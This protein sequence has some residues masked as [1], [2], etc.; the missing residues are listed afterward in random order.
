MATI[1]P[2]ALKTGDEV[3]VIA[4]A[5]SLALISPSVRQIARERLEMELG[6]K[7]TFGKHVEERDRYVSSS[8]KSRVDDLHEAF[9]DKNVKA[10]FSAVGGT[11][12]EELLERIDWNLIKRNP[13]VFCGFSD[14]TTLSNAIYG[15]TGLV[16]FSGPHYSSFGMKRGFEYTM[17]QFKKAVMGTHRHQVLSSANWSDDA[18]YM[19]Q[20]K[21]QFIANLG[22]KVF[23]QGVAKGTIIGGNIGTLAIL[24]GS[25]YMP[26]L[27][28]SILFLEECGDCEGSRDFT[29]RQFGALVRQPGFDKIKGI[30]F[31]RFQK[32]TRWEPTDFQELISRRPELAKRNI[33]II[34]GVDFGHTT[35]IFT[36]GIGGTAEIHADQN[37]AQIFFEPFVKE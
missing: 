24:L 25:S 19:D 10:V 11:N 33:P 21:R 18:W 26:K 30:V 31:G 2:K 17:E 15:K 27:N 32:A 28:N 29:M 3:R 1:Y 5:R 7:V 16:A 13:K 4:P 35:P 6:L 8:I 12:S 9:A 22:M 36:F 34:T 14:I 23:K 37:G 20:E